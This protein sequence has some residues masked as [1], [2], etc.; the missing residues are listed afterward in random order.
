MKLGKHYK[1]LVDEDVVSTAAFLA[2]KTYK[3]GESSQG[4]GGARG[5]KANSK[6][7]TKTVYNKGGY[8]SHAQQRFNEA[9]VHGSAGGQGSGPSHPNSNYKGN[10][11]DPNYQRNPSQSAKPPFRKDPAK[12]DP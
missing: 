12:Q 2:K 4:T 9:A 1:Y 11:Y 7:K 3:K 6:F 8:S 5:Y 10:R